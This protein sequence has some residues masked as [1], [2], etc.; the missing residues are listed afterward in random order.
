MKAKLYG[1]KVKIDIKDD[2]Y[3]HPVSRKKETKVFSA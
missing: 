1:K 2:E 3:I